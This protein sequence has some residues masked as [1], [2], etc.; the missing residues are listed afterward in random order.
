MGWTSSMPGVYEKVMLFPRKH[1]GKRHFRKPKRRQDNN[2]KIGLEET[3]FE[4]MH[5]ARLAHE[6]VQ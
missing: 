1:D 3:A 4:D 2:I 6:E 5:W